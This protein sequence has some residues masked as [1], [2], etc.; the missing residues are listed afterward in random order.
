MDD[1]VGV[2]LCASDCMCG[3]R[4]AMRCVIRVSVDYTVQSVVN[5]LLKGADRFN[6]IAAACLSAGV[7][8]QRI[9]HLEI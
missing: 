2:T 5:R 3:K 8:R 1:V 7:V 9:M 4:V 6:V